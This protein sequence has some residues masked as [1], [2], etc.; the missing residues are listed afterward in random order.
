[1]AATWRF[2]DSPGR[3]EAA[4]D[5]VWFQYHRLASALLDVITIAG[6]DGEPE[7]G[8]VLAEIVSVVPALP[9]G[10][11]LTVSSSIPAVSALITFEAASAS[12]LQGADV[13]VIGI[14][15]QAQRGQSG[16]TVFAFADVPAGAAEVV[17]YEAEATYLPAYT[18][19]IRVTDW[20]PNG[21]ALLGTEVRSYRFGLQ[22]DYSINRDRLVA[23]VNSRS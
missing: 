10:A 21:G 12:V 19:T 16:G 2:S 1:M 8:K 15:W 11:T 18:I 3:L 4:D 20:A 13:P 23:F 22:K 5:T 9:P 17:R 14:D 6:E 7:P